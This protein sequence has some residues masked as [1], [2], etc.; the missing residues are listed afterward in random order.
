MVSFTDEPLK[1]KMSQEERDKLLKEF[2]D[3]GGKVTK[4]KPGIAEG[5]SSMNRSKSLQWSQKDIIEQQK[6]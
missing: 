3:K 1:P 4:L 6:E 5:A 2:L